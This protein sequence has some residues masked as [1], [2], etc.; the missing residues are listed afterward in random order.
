M[1][2]QGWERRITPQRNELTCNERYTVIVGDLM[3]Y[4]I[5]HMQKSSTKSDFAIY[6]TYISH[7]YIT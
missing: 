2:L 1:N 4:D 3:S 6:D 7:I 5:G